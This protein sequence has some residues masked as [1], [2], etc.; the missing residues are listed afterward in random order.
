M[1]GRQQFELYQKWATL[2]FAFVQ[3]FG[4]LTYIRP[5]VTDYN[6]TWLFSSV[7]TLAAGSMM[8]TYVR[9]PHSEIL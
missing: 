8:L 9:S 6:P 5:Y 1:Q 3:A 7:V 2:A 4:Q